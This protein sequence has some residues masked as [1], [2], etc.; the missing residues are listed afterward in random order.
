MCSNLSSGFFLFVFFPSLKE[1]AYI[2]SAHQSILS[3]SFLGGGG[4]AS[5]GISAALT[6]SITVT[7]P[8]LPWLVDFCHLAFTTP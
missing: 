4:G 7:T 2:K 1:T 5:P 8:T 6:L 3:Y